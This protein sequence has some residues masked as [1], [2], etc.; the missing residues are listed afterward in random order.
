MKREIAMKNTLLLLMSVLI[1]TSC[2]Q[3]SGSGIPVASGKG[4]VFS[5]AATSEK[6][7]NPVT[8][9]FD[10]NPSTSWIPEGSAS[11]EGVTIRFLSDIKIDTLAIIPN[12]GPDVSYQVFVNGSSFGNISGSSPLQ[13]DS[14]TVR[15]IYIRCSS[16]EARGLKEV[17]INKAG[18][19]PIVYPGLVMAEVTSSSSL[20]PI[21]SYSPELVFDGR[22]DFGWVEGSQG[23]GI[24]ETLD[25]EFLSPQNFDALYIA[26]GYQRSP[27][28]F[29]KNSRIKEVDV[30][31]AGVSET[32]TLKD[33]DGIQMLKLKSPILTDKLSLRIKSVYPGSKYEDTVISEL[34]F[35]Y[36]GMIFNVSTEYAKKVAKDIAQQL[37]GTFFSKIVGKLLTQE[38]QNKSVTLKL[39]SNGSFVLWYTVSASEYGES[40]ETTE[41]LNKV[42]DG[43]WVIK[44][45]GN[46]LKIQI[47]GRDHEIATTTQ[48]EYGPY[49]SDEEYSN[50]EEDTKI[51][52]DN[53]SIS[54][55]SGE[56]VINSSLLD[57]VFEY[58]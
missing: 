13:I 42:M 10:G 32:Y 35:G 47:F 25:V 6:A 40:S 57:G 48:K 17:Q 11:E 3:K 50:Y 43:N 29:E 56:I 5:V 20:T 37:T 15:T 31:S 44:E 23:Q 21:Q 49:S 36:Q 54:E 38:E 1:I 30:I 33:L 58:Q 41:E 26:N 7:S 45:A 22:L 2:K 46:P 53:L 24:G 51:F 55:Q 19:P 9:A 52:S 27:S 8:Y 14:E 4:N 28:H 18:G 39:R 16:D 34:K 12:A